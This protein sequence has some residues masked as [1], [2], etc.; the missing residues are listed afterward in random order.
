VS[1]SAV[2]GEWGEKEK[3]LGVKRQGSNNKGRLAPPVSGMG[4]TPS[5]PGLE[6]ET[7]YNLRCL[8]KKTKKNTREEKE[9]RKKGHLPNRR[10]GL[11]GKG[12]EG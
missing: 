6:T 12:E 5:T 7:W 2:E 4:E 3:N 11:R 8:G 10:T 9:K 1:D